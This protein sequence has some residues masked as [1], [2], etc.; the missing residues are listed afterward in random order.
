MRSFLNQTDIAAPTPPNSVSVHAIAEYLGELATVANSREAPTA[1]LRRISQLLKTRPGADAGSRLPTLEVRTFGG[2]RVRLPEGWH[3]GPPSKKGGELIQRLVTSASRSVTREELIAGNQSDLSQDQLTHRLHMA[4]CAVRTFLRRCFG[5][6][7]VIRTT[8][9]GYSLSE[10]VCVDSDLSQFIEAHQRRDV[11]A[12]RRAV[13]L[14]RGEF[15]AGELS[16]WIRPIRVRCAT[17]Y[18]DMLSV[19]AQFEFEAADLHA[20]LGYALAAGA[21]DRGHEVA[22]RIAMRCFAGLGQR[23]PILEEYESL[24]TFLHEQLGMEPS[25]ETRALYYS[26]VR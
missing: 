3:E 17:M 8:R 16:D 18:V 24:Q 12:Y 19:L 6:I 21:A 2:F 9:A 5:D 11:E 7:E 10:R 1:R 20:A 15:L 13:A 25:K 23:G 22:S 26:L 4:A 14:Y